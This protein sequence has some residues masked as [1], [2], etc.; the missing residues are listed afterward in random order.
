VSEH[1]ATEPTRGERRRERIV[2]AA[3]RLF[4]ERGFQGTRIEEIGAAVGT[5]GPALYRHFASKEALLEELLQ[6][7]VLRAG[8]DVAAV[9]ARGLPPA[10][11]LEDVVRQAIAHAIE[12]SDLVVMGDSELRVLPAAARERIARGQ[13][14]Y[15]RAWIAL[16]REARPALSPGEARAAVLGTIALIRQ[17]GRVSGLSREAVRELFTRMAL[18]ALLAA[19]E[20]PRSRAR[21]RARAPGRPPAPGPQ[22]RA[23]R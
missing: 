3:A 8:R 22:A 17:V 23:R 1:R 15:V 9:L 10:E 5:T 11:A 19:E 12:E 16:L 4:R 14:E 20:G 2:T 7:A 6:R 18:A 13:R 21:G